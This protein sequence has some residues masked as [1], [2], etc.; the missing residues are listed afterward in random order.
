LLFDCFEIG[1][2]VSFANI[3]RVKLRGEKIENYYKNA[4]ATG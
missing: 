4:I 2:E 1:L 3:E